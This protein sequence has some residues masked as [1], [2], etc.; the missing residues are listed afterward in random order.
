MGPRLPVQA[1]QSQ[2]RI[3]VHPAKMSGTPPPQKNKNKN[4]KTKEQQPD[5]PKWCG[6]NQQHAPHSITWGELLLTW[7]AGHGGNMHEGDAVLVHNVNRRSVTQE[8]SHTVHIAACTQG[9]H[10]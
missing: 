1:A 4:Q 10:V 5:E 2:L 7:V 3:D 8:H 9:A 6:C